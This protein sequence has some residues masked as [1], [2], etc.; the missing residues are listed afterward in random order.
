VGAVHV[1]GDVSLLADKVAH[2]ANGLFV[3][4]DHAAGR[5]AVEQESVVVNG[6]GRLIGG[7][8]A[9]GG[10]VPARTSP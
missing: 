5:D 6:L 3:V 9:D 4:V 10:G 1:A 7:C 8:F 2:V